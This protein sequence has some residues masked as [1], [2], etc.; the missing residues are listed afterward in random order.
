MAWK[1]NWKITQKN[2]LLRGREKSNENRAGIFPTVVPVTADATVVGTVSAKGEQPGPSHVWG[3][4]CYVSVSEQRGRAHLDQKQTI[5]VI[6]GDEP[7]VPEEFWGDGFVFALVSVES[8][9]LPALPPSLHS[10]LLGDRHHRE[11]AS[12]TKYTPLR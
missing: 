5:H 11:A 12:R 4:I 3:A 7:R 10:A 1:S 2:A 6:L 9:I 8:H